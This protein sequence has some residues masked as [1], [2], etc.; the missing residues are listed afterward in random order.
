MKRG[1]LIIVTSAAAVAALVIALMITLVAI[2]PKP[3]PVALESVTYVSYAFGPPAE[4]ERTET[5]PERLQELSTA[6][7]DA[8]WRPGERI[9]RVAPQVTCD[10]G[11][12]LHMRLTFRDGTTLRLVYSSCSTNSPVAEAAAEV[13][14][15]W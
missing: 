8:G 1:T 4:D 12:E 15:S 7:R 3:E 11:S 14:T 9:P 2:Q 13:V 5:S 10:D 6:L